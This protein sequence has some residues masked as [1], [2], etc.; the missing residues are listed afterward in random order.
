VSIREGLRGAGLGARLV[1]ELIVRAIFQEVDSI[2]V[3]VS[4]GWPAPD[5]YERL[6]GFYER[7]GFQADRGRWMRLDL[8]QLR[9]RTDR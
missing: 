2:A 8:R 9:E 1:A 6:V 5:A 3:L 4:P 7:H